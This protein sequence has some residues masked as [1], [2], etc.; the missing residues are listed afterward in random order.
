MQSVLIVSVGDKSTAYFTDLLSASSL[1][2]VEQ[3]ITVQSCGE[4]RRL[5]LERDFDLVIVDAPLRDESGENLSRH[6][7]EKGMSQ[8][9][10]A[11]ASEHYYAISE[12]CEDY[13]VLTI[14]KPINEAIFGASL[15]LARAMQNRFVRMRMENNKLKQKTEDIRIVDSA[16]YILISYL[17][18]S[19]QQAHRYIEKQAMDMRTTRRKIAEG[20]L[21]TY[22][23]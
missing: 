9:I 11:V 13:G 1:Y 23:H 16:K 20:I 2:P 4:A 18:L 14:S 21:K 12:S 8:V 5:L 3:I 7:A 19:E 17:S 6:I 15:K 22:G 10:L